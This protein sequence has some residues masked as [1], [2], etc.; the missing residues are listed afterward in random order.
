MKTP[1]PAP[2]LLLAALLC[3]LAAPAL[4]ATTEQIHNDAGLVKFYRGEFA[5]AM[6]DFQRAL[7]MNPNFADAHYNLGRCL[8]KLGDLPGA[9]AKFEEAL[10]IK[11]DFT[12]ARGARDRARQKLDAKLKKEAAS[13]RRF[14]V[15]VSPELAIPFDDFSEA[16]YAYYA[17]QP[18]RS[19]DL[20]RTMERDNPADF[21]AP[22]EQGVITY[23]LK[24]YD[25]AVKRFEIAR[26]RAPKN[27][28]VLHCLALACEKAGDPERAAGLYAE[29]ARL[30]P[31]FAQ[32]SARLADLTGSLARDLHETARRAFEKGDWRLAA[33]KID[34]ALK[35]AKPGSEEES[36]MRNLQALARVRSGDDAQ[37]QRNIRDAFLAKHHSYD[38]AYDSGRVRYVGDNVI[39]TGVVYRIHERGGETVLVVAWTRDRGVSSDALV[40]TGTCKAKFFQVHC[41]RVLAKDP[42]LAEDSFVEVSGKIRGAESMID[43]YKA[44]CTAPIPGLT[45]YRLVATKEYASGTLVIEPLN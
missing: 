22:F 45:A 11:P 8:E 4:A 34:A 19:R 29:A 42:R 6:G 14:K 32:A 17:S 31:A 39:W 26:E 24:M 37:R 36:A 20:Y 33:E 2:A 12:A 5:D 3:A 40:G 43:G 10:R 27:V 18:D 13:G 15:N 1:R 9:V 16:F 25:E 41:G 28:Q 23:E 30:N 21:R 7:G 35:Y 38:D 44:G